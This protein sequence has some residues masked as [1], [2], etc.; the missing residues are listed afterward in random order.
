M[1]FS[2]K[3]PEAPHLS[4]VPK[5]EVEP[6]ASG[7]YLFVPDTRPDHYAI[8]DCLY[9]SGLFENGVPL[10]QP[11]LKVKLLYG[12]T[13]NVIY[14]MNTVVAIYPGHTLNSFFYVEPGAYYRLGMTPRGAL[15]LYTEKTGSVRAFLH[16]EEVPETPAIYVRDKV[17]V[18]R[19]LSPEIP[20]STIG[21]VF[22]VQN[23]NLIGVERLSQNELEFLRSLPCRLDSYD[24]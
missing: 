13:V 24:S 19:Q 14:E 18:R 6:D 10:T 11:R 17:G 21:A 22:F 8:F 9:E 3:A 1:T 12:C 2:R 5:P 20:A 23:E 15:A 7:V 16:V 4:P